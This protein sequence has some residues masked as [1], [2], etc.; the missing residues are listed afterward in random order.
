M[1]SIKFDSATGSRPSEEL[2]S[3]RLI[4]DREKSSRGMNRNHMQNEKRKKKS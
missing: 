2:A 1:N 4:N 3:I